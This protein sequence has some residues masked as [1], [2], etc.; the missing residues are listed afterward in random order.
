LYEDRYYQEQVLLFY[1]FSIAKMARLLDL[2]LISI[3]PFLH[4]FLTIKRTAAI[5]KHLTNSKKIPNHILGSGIFNVTKNG[6]R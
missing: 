3:S 1:F 4:E 2:H 6:N 5:E